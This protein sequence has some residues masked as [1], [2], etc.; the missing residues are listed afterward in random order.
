PAPQQEPQGQEQ[1]D[2]AT[3][4][5]GQN[6]QQLSAEEPLRD[7]LQQ[8]QNQQRYG[9]LAGA[10]TGE[11]RSIQFENDNMIVRFNT[12]GGI[13]E[14]VE[15]KDYKTYYQKPLV[16]LDQESNAM[17]ML[18]NTEQGVVDLYDLYYQTSS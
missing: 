18:V 10:A 9:S 11:A 6:Q 15:L 14:Y 2:P 7:S 4:D 8:L 5:Q 3:S 16:L 17:K 13:L 1:V 12:K